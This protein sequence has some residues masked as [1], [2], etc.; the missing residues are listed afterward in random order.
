MAITTELDISPAQYSELTYL[1]GHYLPGVQVWAFGSRTKGTARSHSDLDLVVFSDPTQH[2]ALSALK[3]ALE[4]S[5]LPFRV[6]LLVW[7]TIPESFR[8]NI[9][10]HY[11]VIREKNVGSEGKHE[12]E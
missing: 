8:A 3:E 10:Q 11:T 1:L 5:A 2:D 9:A 12:F 6:D 7:D 4:E